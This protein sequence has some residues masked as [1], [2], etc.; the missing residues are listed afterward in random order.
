MLDLTIVPQRGRFDCG[1]AAVATLMN[2]SYE[3][4]RD[5]LGLQVTSAGVSLLP[6]MPP[7][8][9]AGVAGTYL[10]PRERARVAPEI[11]DR[12]AIRGLPT[13]EEVHV[14]L[15]GRRAVICIEGQSPDG[16]VGPNFGHAVA[17]DGERMIEC[18]ATGELARPSRELSFEN[19]PLWEA[20]V[21]TDAATSPRPAPVEARP[22]TEIDGADTTALAA[23]FERY[24][25]VFLGFSGGKE[26][27]ALTHM[28]EPWR[29]RVTLL[30]VNTGVMAP[31]MAEFIRGFR[32]R[33]WTLEELPSPNLIE[34]WMT[35][36]TP[37]EVFPQDNVTGLAQPRLQPWAHCC[38]VIRQEPLNAFLRD[39][40]GPA[41]LINGQRRDDL[42]GATVSGLSSQLP[43][44]VEVVQPLAG[45][46]E[47]DVLSYVDRH[48]LALP[49]Q[50]AAGYRDSIECTI[51]PAPMKA[52]RM[53]YLRRHYPDAAE[54]AAG[55]ARHA[56]AATINHLSALTPIVAEVFDASADATHPPSP[57]MQDSP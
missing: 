30:W 7:L 31:H 16:Q 42:G 12:Q 20:L 22:A 46:S 39:Q 1:I 2:W 11:A 32:A 56:Y 23:L 25:R 33:G 13:V 24:E 47:T 57:K 9:A 17:W 36:G 51:C 43:S 26:S 34:H 4:A 8:L 37:A 27:V 29:D 6:M 40:E 49:S 38:R 10:L 55:Q 14:L 53:R 15:K 54:V 19:Y 3:R 5:V 44:S 18:G 35:A 28:L 45:W 41:C 50:Y 52:E 21:F 48:G